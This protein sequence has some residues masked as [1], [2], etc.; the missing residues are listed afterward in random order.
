MPATNTPAEFIPTA[1]PV[2]NSGG[3]NGS[4]AAIENSV[5]SLINSQRSAA[6]VGSVSLSSSLSE[7]ARSYSR[8]MA[9]GEILYAGR[10]SDNSA[11]AAVNAWLDSP[12]HR[13]KMLNPIYTLA[14]VGYW[15]DPG[16]TYGGYYT[17]DFA[18]PF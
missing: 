13:E 9:V 10:D 15:C 18:K 2:N 17:V 8:S 1:I 3:C 16:S 12:P 4:D 7:I 6:G 11:T 5:L 14:G